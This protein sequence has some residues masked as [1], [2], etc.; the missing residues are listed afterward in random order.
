VKPAALLLACTL[1]AAAVPLVTNGRSPYSICL[2]PQSSP[3]EQHAADELQR[4]LEQMSGARLPVTGQCHPAAQKLVFVGAG[5]ALKQLAP[6]LDP[7]SAGSE[8][9]YLKTQGPHLI[10]AGGRL[11][12]SLYGVYTFLDRLGVRWFTPEV[13]RV[14]RR[15]AIET[16]P[17]DLRQRPAFEYRDV[18][19]TEALDR[20]WAARNR[21][22]GNFAKLDAA[23]GGRV[24]YYPFVHSFY[25]L[26][27][28]DNYFKDHPEYFSLIEGKRR[29]DRG[30][31]CL[32]NPDVLRL[33]VSRVLE[34]IRAHPEA[35]IFSVSQN[36]WQGWCECDNC[37]R[38]EQEEGGTHSGPILRF[39]N[40]LAEQIAPRHPDKL[41]DTLAYWYSEDPPAKVR[42][43]PNVRIRLCPIGVCESHPYEKCP[44]SAYFIKN[45]KA[46][47]QITSQL[48][49]WHYNTNFSHYLSPFPDFDEL[50]ADIPLYQRSGVVGIFL[51]GAYPPGGGGESAEL[52]SYVMARQLWDPATNVPQAINEFLD[53]VYGKAAPAMKDYYALLRQQGRANHLWI[54]NL[55][56]FPPPVLASARSHLSR[57]QSLAEN[58]EVRKRVRKA[59]L[60]VEYLE[61]TYSGTYSVQDGRFAPAN[62]ASLTTRWLDFIALLRTFGIQ[63]IHEGRDL[64]VDERAAQSLRSFPVVTL[65]NEHWSLDLMPDLSGRV[66][67]MTSKAAG[68]NL[69]R[70]AAAGEGG[71]PDVGGLHLSAA[72]DFV[73][74]PWPA[75]W[76]LESSDASAADLKAS[77]AN[78]LAL[79]RRIALQGTVVRI[80]SEARN[81]SSSP[82]EVALQARADLAP[83][84]IDGAQVEFTS[85]AGSP[86][87]RKLILPEQQP[88][89]NVIWQGSEAPAGAWRIPGAECRFQPAQASRVVADWT[90][91]G[92]PR[93]TLSVWS[94]PALL[95]PGATLRLDTQYSSSR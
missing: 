94:K 83:L 84:D 72:S 22:N 33:S 78:G 68:R 16:G 63:S 38:V 37:R 30:Q 90:A 92:R 55:P 80:E 54:F 93:V 4:F 14:P 59:S 65:E 8:G 24:Q 3:S 35:T 87:L 36:D 1:P 47:H 71:Y 91:K 76:E 9:F 12:G 69:L 11:R 70:T 48:Y 46:W 27:P 23:T 51:E 62:L 43:L 19:F 31:L 52:R 66:L 2:D 58:D 67:R 89:G 32:T 42:P 39:V 49:I 64:A 50:A 95:A 6:S 88:N 77:C 75:Q 57:A 86:V 18:Y 13:T 81:T 7:E 85:Q 61:L 74:R 34:W 60:P 20:D 29:V 45:L 79:R 5:A 44:R 28:P 73:S 56:E 15:A 17:L 21:T 10:I 25:E 40:A 41:I 53:G 82:L 26:I